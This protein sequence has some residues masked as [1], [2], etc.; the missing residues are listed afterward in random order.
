[1]RSPGGRRSETP[2]ACRPGL[3]ALAVAPRWRREP[4]GTPRC[5]MD[6]LYV[7]IRVSSQ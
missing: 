7:E 2:A 3:S 4:L 6:R 1:M 5:A